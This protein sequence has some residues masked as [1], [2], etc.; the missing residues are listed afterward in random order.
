MATV[1]RMT[2][3]TKL[4]GTLAAATLALSLS[5]CTGGAQN[6]DE[7]GDV[8]GSEQTRTDPAQAN[9]QPC[10]RVLSSALESLQEVVGDEPVQ[11]GY[12]VQDGDLWYVAAPV[13]EQNVLEDE[14]SVG[15]WTTTEDVES[16]SFEGGWTPV[17]E[18]AEEQSGSGASGA[19]S[20]DEDS[21]AAER[22][23][24]CI[25]DAGDEAR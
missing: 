18:A 1:D 16:D 2:A 12:A 6:T 3:T 19:S 20:A 13:G 14:D 8:P 25:T 4:L 11:L 15:L 21:D 24:S 23:V 22:A 7:A 5:A 17:N 9:D 10:T